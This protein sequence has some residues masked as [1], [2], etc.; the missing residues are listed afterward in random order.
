MTA[1]TERG[2]LV[3]WLT[4]LQQLVRWIDDRAQAK[5]AVESQYRAFLAF[6][7]R[8]G[9]WPL[10]LCI[11]GGLLISAMFSALF[12]E[13]WVGALS[14][15]DGIYTRTPGIA[16]LL[17]SVTQ[18]IVGGTIGTVFWIFR[19]KSAFKANSN[20]ERMNQQIDEHNQQ[21]YAQAQQ[22]AAQLNEAGRIYTSRFAE[23]YPDAYAYDDAVGFAIQAVQNHR[24][25]T[26]GDA[27]NLYEQVLHQQRME[28]SQQAMLAEQERT[29]KQMAVGFVVNAALQGATIAAVNNAAS[30]PQTVHHTHTWK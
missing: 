21:T 8:W 14:V 12:E 6:K 20:A 13:V 15:Q 10:I 18:W 23:G 3:A 17:A 5:N 25:N 9:I 28:Q 27:I 30:R 29:R 1:P 26:V 19:N 2:A 16:Y 11:V 24:A 7:R 4:E 22:I